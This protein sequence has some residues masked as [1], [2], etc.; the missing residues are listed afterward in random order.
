MNDTGPVQLPPVGLHDIR[1]AQK[2]I[3]GAVVATPCPES[4]GL[5]ALCHARVFCKLEYMQR[6]A[7]FKERGVANALAHFRQQPSNK[8]KGVIAASAG[9]HALA[10]AYHGRRLDIPVT[11]V[12]PEG[13]P[14]IK[15]TNCRRLGAEVIKHGRS[16]R[17]AREH[18]DALALL[19]GLMY[20]HGYDD[21]L[22][23]AGQGTVG[24]ELLEQVPDMEAVVVPVGGTGLIAGVAAAVKAIRPAV[25]I[26]GVEPEASASYT[27]ALAQG[28]PVAVDVSPTCADGL[29]VGQV[30][31]LA[32]VT[33][34]PLVD[35]VVT[36]SEPA[37]TLA[38]YRLI[39]IEKAVV[40]GAGAAGLAAMLAGKLP[41]LA[42]R[43]VVLLLSGGNI[44][45]LVLQR[46]VEQGLTADGR[47]RR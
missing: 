37:L 42:G 33:A 9:N 11:V 32:F 15:A 1:S 44:D 30:G 14:L 34:R 16:F 45:P 36:V 28:G 23:I 22:V 26:I 10:L 38:I 46:M 6:T 5:S 47:P 17:E 18:A 8:N 19:R 4:S 39:E 24:L 29:A 40:E 20:L 21:P 13:A 41:E 25:Q 31:R 2:Q 12:M 43:T 27:A 7:S 35:R 3:A